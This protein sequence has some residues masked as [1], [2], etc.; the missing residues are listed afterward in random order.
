MS[1]AL[2]RMERNNFEFLDA[3]GRRPLLTA[4]NGAV[5][6][7]ERTGLDMPYQPDFIEYENI[8]Q[9]W[10][11][12]NAFDAL[13]AGP[14]Q[15]D[16][17]DGQVLAELSAYPLDAN[18]NYLNGWLRANGL[19]PFATKRLASPRDWAL[20]QPWPIRAW[21]STGPSTCG[22]SARSGRHRLMRS[23]ATWSWR[24]ATFRP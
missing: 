9:T 16:Y 13:S 24:C 8:F 1:L 4:M 5:G 6:Y 11:T 14:A 2:S 20:C 19:T 21:T 15:R 7:R 22:V 3:L 18:L 12:V 10:G 23:A 17:S